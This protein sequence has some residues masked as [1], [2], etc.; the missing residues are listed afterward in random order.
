MQMI[1]TFLCL[2]LL[3]A[4]IIMLIPLNLLLFATLLVP[5]SLAMAEENTMLDVHSAGFWGQIVAIIALV[6]CSGIVAGMYPKD[7][8]V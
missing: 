4:I 3:F 7:P 8:C 2:F 1:C 5:C 6:L